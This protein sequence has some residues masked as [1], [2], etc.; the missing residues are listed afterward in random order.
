MLNDNHSLGIV[1]INVLSFIKYIKVLHVM[2]IWVKKH[3]YEAHD[4][5]MYMVPIVDGGRNEEK[6]THDEAPWHNIYL[7]GYVCL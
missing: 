1:L 3:Y 2:R 5:Y 7:Y 6:K 4:T